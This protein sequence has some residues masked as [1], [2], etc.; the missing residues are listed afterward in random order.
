MQGEKHTSGVKTPLHKAAVLP[1]INPRPT[2]PGLPF[3]VPGKTCDRLV[4]FTFPLRIR[5][6]E[7]FYAVGFEIP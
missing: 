4:V 2:V 6:L 3:P 5:P 1:G 7:V